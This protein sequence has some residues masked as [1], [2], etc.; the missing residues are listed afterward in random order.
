MQD[1]LE[2]GWRRDSPIQMSKAPRLPT[3]SKT[4]DMALGLGVA[5]RKNGYRSYCLTGKLHCYKQRLLL[6]WSRGDVFK[7]G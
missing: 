6:F 5:G 1:V 3:F 7:A 4:I 2:L